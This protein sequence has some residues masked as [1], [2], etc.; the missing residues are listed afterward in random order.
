VRIASAQDDV[1]RA[2]A[3]ALAAC[4]DEMIGRAWGRRS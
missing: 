4:G 2:D 3:V 1:S